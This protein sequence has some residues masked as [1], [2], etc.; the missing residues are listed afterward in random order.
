MGTVGVS[1]LS[2]CASTSSVKEL[3][4]EV[5]DMRVTVTRAADDA[6]EAKRIASEADA[7]AVRT[8]EMVNRGFQRSMR[9]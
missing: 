6:A 5:N 7:R 9:K 4:R 2:G 1:L 8:E 3:E